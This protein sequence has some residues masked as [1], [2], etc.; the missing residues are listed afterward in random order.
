MAGPERYSEHGDAIDVARLMA[1]LALSETVLRDL[2]SLN[3]PDAIGVASQSPLKVASVEAALAIVWPERSFT[4]HGVYA[5]SGVPEQPLG[6][7]TFDGALNRLDGAQRRYSGNARDTA[8]F[9]I[10][11]GL[12]RVAAHETVDMTATFDPEATYED[13]AVVALQLPGSPIA[14]AVS[15]A[16]EAVTYPSTAIQE[17][18]AKGFVRTTAAA[19]LAAQGM[20]TDPQNPHRK[21]TRNRPGGPLDRR[22]QMA[23]TM[24]RGLIHLMHE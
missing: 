9:S 2:A 10:E 11:N 19:V 16:T 18:Y 7:Q 6:K 13:R 4:V 5:P 15:P 20:V 12:F 14:V 3:M 21:L 23:R 22:D 8:W 17:A 1:N 24:L